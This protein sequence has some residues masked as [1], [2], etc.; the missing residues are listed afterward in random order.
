MK[1]NEP[2]GFVF[3]QGA[4]LDRSIWQPVTDGLDLPYLLI[5]FPAQSRQRAEQIGLRVKRAN[6]A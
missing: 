4:G 2:A 6:N 1:P 3:I 5:D